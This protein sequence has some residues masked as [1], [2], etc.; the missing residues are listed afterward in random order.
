MSDQLQ[1]EITLRLSSG[2]H[3][4][5]IYFTDREL[6]WIFS[7]DYVDHEIVNDV[8]LLA[9]YTNGILASPLVLSMRIVIPR[10]TGHEFFAGLDISPGGKTYLEFSYER[11]PV[12]YRLTEIRKGARARVRLDAAEPAIIRPIA[13]PFPVP[14]SIPI[15]IGWIRVPFRTNTGDIEHFNLPERTSR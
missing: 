2:A 8:R 4:R 1:H 15:E 9:N 14:D 5:I 12:I 13:F 7:Y 6:R 10:R 3:L 11:S